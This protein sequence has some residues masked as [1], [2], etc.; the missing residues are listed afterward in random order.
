[1]M[2]TLGMFVFVLKTTPYQELQH[3][4]AWRHVTN[5]RIGQRP[6]TQFTG[7]GDETITLSGTLY[8][9]ITGGTISLQVLEWMADEGKAW[10]LIEGTGMIYGMYVI[11]SLS[12]T[13]SY[14]SP[15]G[16]ANKIEFTLS[17]QRVDASLTDLLGDM[18]TQL[19][20]IK[21]TAQAQISDSVGKLRD[22]VGKRISAGG[23]A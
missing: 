14:F 2:M 11:T 1:M 20:K 7:P 22:A 15:D 16:Y 6:A 12:R 23:A 19:Q 9:E 21:D 13:R 10:P 8:P 5:S 3:D 17:L 18:G 4:M